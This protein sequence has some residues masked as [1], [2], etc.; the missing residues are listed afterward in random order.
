MV[1]GL[2][3]ARGVSGSLGKYSHFLSRMAM[4]SAR[5][6]REQGYGTASSRRVRSDI[7]NAIASNMGWSAFYSMLPQAFMRPCPMTCASP[8]SAQLRTLI[9]AADRAEILLQVGET[10]DSGPAV[11]GVLIPTHTL[12]E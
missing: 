8:L 7:T 1:S 12:V 9:N 4:A 10:V 3:L 11:S 6:H 5:H 2:T